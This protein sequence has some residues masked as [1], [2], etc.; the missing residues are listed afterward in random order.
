MLRFALLITFV[1]AWF[2][3]SKSCFKCSYR[4]RNFDFTNLSLTNQYEYQLPILSAQAFNSE[5]KVKDLM[6]DSIKFYKGQTN[7]CDL[8][9]VF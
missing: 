8:S 5:T 3:H 4:L 1:F 9:A 6:I 2:P 7:L